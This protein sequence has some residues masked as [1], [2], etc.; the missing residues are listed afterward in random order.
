MSYIVALGTAK[1][2]KAHTVGEV[3]IKPYW[4]QVIKLILGEASEKKMQQVSLSKTTI[5]R[6]ISDTPAD[7]G[8]WILDKVK[9]FPL[10]L[11]QVDE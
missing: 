4:L 3:L 9:A 6:R 10:L 2:K 7:V 5:K 1:Q 11:F 8:K